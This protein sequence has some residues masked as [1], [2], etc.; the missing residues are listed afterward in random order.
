MG[1][2]SL[3][4]MNSIPTSHFRVHPQF[5]PLVLIYE[6]LCDHFCDVQCCCLL[7]TNISLHANLSLHQNASTFCQVLTPSAKFLRLH[8]RPEVSSFLS[9][10]LPFLIK[11]KIEPEQLNGCNPPSD[12]YKEMYPLFTWE[13]KYVTS[14]F[15]GTVFCCICAAFYC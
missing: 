14:R 2:Q 11:V 12:L 3:R 13:C 5:S 7:W 6:S 8:H 15:L 10:T 9:A 4:L 1:P